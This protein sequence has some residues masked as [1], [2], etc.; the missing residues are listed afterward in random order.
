M[1]IQNKELKQISQKEYLYEVKELLFERY[2]IFLG[3]G[4]KNP[5]FECFTKKENNELIKLCDVPILNPFQEKFKSSVDMDL[6]NRFDEI[7]EKSEDAFLYTLRNIS[8]IKNNV[9]INDYD[10]SGKSAIYMFNGMFNVLNRNTER[11]KI[12]KTK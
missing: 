9:P 12:Y 2:N 3:T 5:N 10:E 1:K 4:H 8:V 6:I 7:V 11:K